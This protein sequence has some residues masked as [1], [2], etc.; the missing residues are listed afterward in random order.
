M[1]DALVDTTRWKKKTMS[2]SKM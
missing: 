2:K 1:L